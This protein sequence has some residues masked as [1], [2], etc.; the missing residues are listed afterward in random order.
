[1]EIIKS[2][3]NKLIKDLKKLKQKKYRDSEEKFLA[4]G[5]KFLDYL[6][7]IPE[8]IIIREDTLENNNYLDKIS[9]FNVKK[10][11]IDKKLFS[12]LT[13]QESSQGILI[14]YKKKKFDI[15]NLSDDIVILDDVSDPGNLGTII[16]ICDAADFKDLILTKNSVDAYN[17]KVIRAS[18]GS[19]LNINIIYMERE[20]I[21]KTLKEN[22]YHSFATYLDK[23]SLQY[24]KIE[25][26]NKNAIILGNEARGVGKDFLK[27][28][29]TKTI[30]PILGNAESLNV[31]V[32]SALVLYKFRE[33]QNYF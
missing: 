12:E 27:I 24:N 20:E 22:K 15:K 6:Q 8:M 30:I 29:E 9:K 23:N 7:Y 28:A 19:I 31:A 16:R 4:E 18:M 17:E 10:I 33:L 2:K 5:V 13:S 3:E 25:V 14:L 32:A 1:M 21:L 26:K 11:F